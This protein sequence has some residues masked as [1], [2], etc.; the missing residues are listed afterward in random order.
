MK[1]SRLFL[2]M[3]AMLIFATTAFAQNFSIDAYRSF[4]QQNKD[5]SPAGMYDLYP[6]GLYN[7]EVT[8]TNDPLYLDSIS[9][10]ME[11]TAD[12]LSLI[13]RHGFVVTERKS[14]A[15]M[16]DA[17][18]E[19][20]YKDLPVIITTDMMLHAL[21]MSYDAILKD[22]EKYAFIPQLEASLRQMRQLH[23]SRKHIADD[24]MMRSYRDVDIYLTVALDLLT[25]EKIDPIFAQNKEIVGEIMQLIETEQAA[26]Y[27]LFQE[28]PKKLDFSQF[29]IRGHYT[30]SPELGRYFQS[31]IWLGRTELY[32]IAPKEDDCGPS[33]EDVRRQIIDS[34]LLADLANRTSA[35]EKLAA[36]NTV[37]ESLVGESD[38]V[39][40]DHL[41]QLADEL[42]I[43]DIS[44]FTDMNTVKR[45]QDKLAEKSYAGQKIL[46]Q[47]L[48]SDPFD[49]EQIVPASAFMLMGQRFVI[50]SYV[51]GNVVYDKI[52]YEGTKVRRML[53]SHLDILFALGNNAAADLLEPELEKYHYAQNLTGLRYLIDSYGDDF[54]KSAFYNNW[55]N[56]IRTL[57]PETDETREHLPDFMRTAAWWQHKMNTQLASWA[58]LRH[59]NLLYAKQSYSGGVS[60]EYPYGYVEPEP[61]FYVAM[62]D[63]ADMASTKLIDAM[64]VLEVE[65]DGEFNYLKN[66]TKS[67][68]LNMKE[69]AEKLGTISEKEIAGE[70]LS[71]S[72]TEF[73]LSVFQQRDVVCAVEPSGWYSELFYNSDVE[74]NDYVVADVHTAPTDEAGNMVGWVWHVGTGHINLLVV[75]AKDAEGREIAFA[76]PVMSYY[77]HVSTNF[78]RLTDE[79]WEQ[80]YMMSHGLRPEFT[81]LYLADTQGDNKYTNPPIL[82]TVTTAVDY[83]PEGEPAIS[84]R[85]NPLTESS[86]IVVSLPGRAD[87]YDADLAIYDA[88]GQRV[89][90]MF[91]GSIA[92]GNYVARWNGATDTGVPVENGV[93]MAR[94]V[95]GDRV[96]SGKII[97]NK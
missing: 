2:G 47:I 70:K 54:W 38:N 15:N 60:C 86:M 62:S 78:K 21:H 87:L 17:L 19:I 89:A 68:F 51:S 64:D 14:Y 53:P 72:E 41:G 16:W 45:F 74:V 63:L 48:M 69:V 56:A 77:E 20:Y 91:A 12:E 10:K 44:A 59:D 26:Q 23:S 97:V 33:P 6:V 9:I 76:G 83:Q 29:T 37:L 75:K 46:S 96:Y 28:R 22:I 36:I 82:P 61:D 8:Q 35:G 42:G 13:G 43:E 50:D 93:Y 92:G 52:I 27:P 85:P 90:S 40:I 79:E 25:T 73:V 95:I 84:I 4:L 34:Y 24:I 3:A 32:L 67:Y 71:G 66:R 58:Q 81:R 5:I 31:M 57:N 7:K 11:M 80:S 39:R 65:D 30:D 88:A 55:L 1:K 49:T 94:L 18:R